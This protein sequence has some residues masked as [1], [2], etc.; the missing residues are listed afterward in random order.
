MATSDSLLRQRTSDDADVDRPKPKTDTTSYNNKA[1]RQRRTGMARRGLR[2]LAIAVALPAALQ[3]C[4][5]GWANRAPSAHRPSSSW[6]LQAVS[7]VSAS[8]MGLCAWLVWAEGGFHQKPKALA[9]FLGYLGLSLAWDPIVFRVGAAWV[10]LLVSLAMFGALAG[11]SRIFK[12]VNPI[13]G[14]LVKLCLIWAGFVVSLNLKLLY[15]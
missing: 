10:G 5:L 3:L 1:R 9:F 2:S 8:L 6:I 11:C 4:F 7:V 15:W 14:D 12:E 13:A